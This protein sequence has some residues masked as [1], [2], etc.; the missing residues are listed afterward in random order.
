M[1]DTEKV[2]LAEIIIRRAFKSSPD[3]EGLVA[4]MDA[5]Y[6]VLTWGDEDGNV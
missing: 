2:K 3:L 1:T 5:V 6:R 4:Y